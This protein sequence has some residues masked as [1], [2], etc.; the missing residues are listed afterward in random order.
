MNYSATHLTSKVYAK[1]YGHSANDKYL[2]NFLTATDY[3]HHPSIQIYNL[4]FVLL[5][6]SS[7][8]D[9]PTVP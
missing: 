5:L 3:F 1:N 9:S 6:L 2:F 8:V 7:V 4:K